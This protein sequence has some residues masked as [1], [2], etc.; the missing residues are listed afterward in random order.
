MTFLID[1]EKKY[2]KHIQ[3][4]DATE[5]NFLDMQKKAKEVSEHLTRVS[6]VRTG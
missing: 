3:N 4:K 1:A 2:K 5:K 6:N